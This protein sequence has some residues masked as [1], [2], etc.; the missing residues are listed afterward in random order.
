MLIRGITNIRNQNPGR[1]QE[2]LRQ[3][4]ELRNIR[5]ISGQIHVEMAVQSRIKRVLHKISTVINPLNIING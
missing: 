4:I 2:H 3:R 5:I 1:R